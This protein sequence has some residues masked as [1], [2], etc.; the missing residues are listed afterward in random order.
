MSEPLNT[1]YRTLALKWPD[2]QLPLALMGAAVAVFRHY[3]YDDLYALAVLLALYAADWATGVLAAWKTG[4]LVSRKLA[5][6]LL[7]ITLGV[8]LLSISWHFSR[9]NPALNTALGLLNSSFAGL[10]YFILTSQL[11]LSIVENAGKLGLLPADSLAALRQR[12][13]LRRLLGS[14][15]QEAP[16]APAE[17]G[18]DEDEPA[19]QTGKE[20]RND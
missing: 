1:L 3:V 4:T 20:T 13:S 10:F 19:H 2:V 14:P 5:N 15:P 8:G 7:N 18:R 16:A 17:P 12:L 11:F 6:I 9:A